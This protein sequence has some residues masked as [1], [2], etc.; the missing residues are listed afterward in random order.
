MVEKKIFNK[1][2]IQSLKLK[3]ASITPFL[4]KCET[5]NAKISGIEAEFA[6]KKAAAKAALEE[7]IQKLDT[8]YQEKMDN[9]VAKYKQEI[10]DT[11]K[12]IDA[13]NEIVKE[14]TGGYCI[15]DL[16]YR[17]GRTWNLKYPDT[18]IPPVDVANTGSD[19]DIDVKV[20]Q[21]TGEVMDNGGGVQSTE[22]TENL[23]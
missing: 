13:V 11:Q 16:L 19:H 21:E 23:W 18:V 1:F 17:D 20:N 4:K 5:L 6:Q 8:E 9:A 10:L 3:A 14:E 12:G 22:S 2:Y 7:K 15:E